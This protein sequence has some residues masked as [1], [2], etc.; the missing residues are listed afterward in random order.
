M[1]RERPERETL[2]GFSLAHARQP[3]T[4]WPAGG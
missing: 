1:F 2:G 3:V 4:G